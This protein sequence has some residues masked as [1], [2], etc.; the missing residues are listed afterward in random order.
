M[1]YYKIKGDSEWIA[2]E[3]TRLIEAFTQ[4]KYIVQFKFEG[5]IEIQKND[6]GTFKIV[7]GCDCTNISYDE[8]EKIITIEYIPSPIPKHLV[9]K[10][11]FY[12]TVSNP[13]REI[14]VQ[15]ITKDNEG[16]LSYTFKSLF[17]QAFVKQKNTQ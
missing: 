8:K 1:W 14:V 13:G 9:E 16:N 5:D 2:G 15:Y 10:N 4:T 6:N 7:S 12:Y 17:I 3:S 11:Q